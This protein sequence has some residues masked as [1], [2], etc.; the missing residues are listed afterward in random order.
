MQSLAIHGG[1]PVRAEP[2]AP[3]GESFGDEEIALLKVAAHL[4]GGG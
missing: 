3:V 2:I 4:A 1:T